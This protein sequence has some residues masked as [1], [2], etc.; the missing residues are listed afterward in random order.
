MM[1]TWGLVVTLFTV[2]VVLG[3]SRKGGFRPFREGEG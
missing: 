1:C 2:L 3:W